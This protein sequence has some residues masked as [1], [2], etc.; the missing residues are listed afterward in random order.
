MCKCNDRCMR[1]DEGFR[2]HVK[3]LETHWYEVY[4]HPFHDIY[5]IKD[6]WHE[7]CEEKEI[8]DIETIPEEVYKLGN[9]W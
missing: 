9:K 8:T 4:T 5:D 2:S 3:N 7:Y 6:L 1:C